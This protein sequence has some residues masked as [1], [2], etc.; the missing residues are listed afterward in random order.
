M[1]ITSRSMAED[2]SFNAFMNCY[3]REVD[4]G[5]WAPNKSAVSKLGEPEVSP[6]QAEPW[7]VDLFLFEV[8]VTLRLFVEY[9]SV[10]GRHTI[11]DVSMRVGCDDRGAEW[12]IADKLYVMVSVVQNIYKHKSNTAQLNGHGPEKIKAQ[13]IELLARLCDSYQLMNC[14]IDARKFDAN[15]NSVT[16]LASEQSSLYGHWLHPTPKSR[17]GMSF[18]QQSHY[19]PELC[20]CFKLHYF[21]VDSS[22]VTQGS[23]LPQSASDI[24]LDEVR[25]Y[26]ELALAENHLLIPQHPLQAHFLL[27]NDEVRSLIADGRLDYLGE[28][29]AEFTP[30]SSVRTLFNSDSPW[31]YKFSI[32]V[33]ITNSLRTNMRDELEDG[34]EVE[35]YLRKVGFLK[36]RPQFKLVDD[37]AYIT[38]NL[39]SCRDKE[40]GFE[41]VLRRNFV[42]GKADNKVCSVLALAQDPVLVEEGVLQDSLLKQLIH[43]L[44]IEEVRSESAVA[45]DWFVR[46]FE[47]AIESLIILYDAHGIALEAHQQNSLLDL[48][49]GYPS[50]YYYRDNQGFYLS[51]KYADTLHVIDDR[52]TMSEMFYDDEKIFEALA[53]YVFFNQLFAI[54]Q[55]LGVDGLATEARLI[56]LVRDRLIL[57]RQKLFGV[58]QDFIDYMLKQDFIA[59]KTNLLARVDDIDELHNGMETS[60]YTRIA[61]PL[62]CGC[63]TEQKN[64]QKGAL[65][66]SAGG[67]VDY[68]VA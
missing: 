15:L 53:Y 25:Q 27:L 54:I 21:S 37:P 14:Y 32:P 59:C 57:L 23:V 61:N 13:E 46:Y 9:R 16:F 24:V 7:Y 45:E 3:L 2:A 49:D 17:Q 43:R 11:V 19:S 1:K 47:C 38:V 28:L 20:G 65:S 52:L 39:P 30:T 64:P 18:W 56:Q 58:G 50:A 62:F 35:K 67:E 8:R 10:V 40:S 34:M 5:I 42:F 44:A 51:R 36:A 4:S 55:R 41:V 63:E 6:S 48:S 60:V 33:K 12:Q 29:G 31:M 26:G 22:L 68:H 66:E